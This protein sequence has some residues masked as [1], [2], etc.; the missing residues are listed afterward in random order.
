M[1]H[2]VVGVL[3]SFFL[4]DKFFFVLK[5]V[6]AEKFKLVKYV[7][8]K[9]ASLK[10]GFVFLFSFY[11]SRKLACIVLC[12]AYR[13]PNLMIRSSCLTRVCGCSRRVN[14]SLVNAPFAI[15]HSNMTSNLKQQNQR[16]L[17]SKL[18]CFEHTPF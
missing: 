13:K 1:W 16:E 4:M 10:T 8:R 7:V 3:E 18:S 9:K 11:F 6:P 17:S 5:Q 12:S 14:G 2:V 15:H